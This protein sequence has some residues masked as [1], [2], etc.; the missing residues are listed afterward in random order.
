MASVDDVLAEIDT[1][2]AEEVQRAPL[3]YNTEIYNQMHEARA[4]LK[5]RLSVVMTGEPLQPPKEP[6]AGTDQGGQAEEPETDL[7]DPPADQ[8]K[9]SSKSKAG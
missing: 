6:D 2:F 4:S 1:W 3:S 8:G 5:N 9:A 7:S